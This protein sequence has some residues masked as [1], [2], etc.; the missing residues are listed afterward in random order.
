MATGKKY[1]VLKGYTY[2]AGKELKFSLRYRCT[3]GCGA[4]LYMT[5][6]RKLVEPVPV[7]NHPPPTL[8]M[9]SNGTYIRTK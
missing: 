5:F 7:H 6:D 8:Y 1:Q 3:M 9:L 4:Y 2:G